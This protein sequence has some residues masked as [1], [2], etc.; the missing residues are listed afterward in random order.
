M[1]LLTPVL[2]V[3]SVLPPAA[4]ASSDPTLADM[5]GGRTP[6]RATEV[7]ALVTRL[8]YLP[9]L[10]SPD[11]ARQSV[12]GHFDSWCGKKAGALYFQSKGLLS[13]R[14]RSDSYAVWVEQDGG[15][16]V[17]NAELPGF[18]EALAARAYDTGRADPSGQP[19]M[20]RH[21]TL[22]ADAPGLWRTAWGPSEIVVNRGDTVALRLVNGI[23]SMNTPAGFVLEGYGV[24]YD[25]FPTDGRGVAVPPFVADRAGTFLFYEVRSLN[26]AAGVLIVRER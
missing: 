12:S 22:V 19:E 10:S 24:R 25:V 18:L 20:T 5:L 26:R 14:V 16:A 15:R 21:F 3:L 17:K 9:G 4:E 13:G 8:D 11:D 6:C 2:A 23:H 7:S 1:T